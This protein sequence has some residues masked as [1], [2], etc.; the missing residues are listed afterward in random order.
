MNQSTTDTKGT[1]MQMALVYQHV[2]FDVSY[3][4]QL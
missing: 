1:N 3:W 2:R 4:L